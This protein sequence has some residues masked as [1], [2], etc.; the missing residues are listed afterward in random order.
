MNTSFENIP[1]L[2]QSK[3]KPKI[4]EI[5]LTIDGTRRKIFDGNCWQYLCIGD[6]N[7]RIQAKQTC[8]YH[9]ICRPIV[10]EV[11]SSEKKSSSITTGEIQMLPNGSRRIWRGARWHS[12]CRVDNCNIQAKDFCKNHQNQRMSLPNTSMK[13]FYENNREFVLS[14]LEISL[15]SQSKKRAR[16]LV[17]QSAKQSI[18]DLPSTDESHPVKEKIIQSPP[19]SPTQKRELHTRNGRLVRCN[20]LIWKH[21][22]AEKK[23]TILKRKYQ[24]RKAIS[25]QKPS[26]IIES[27]PAPSSDTPQSST[28]K[29]MTRT[30]HKRKITSDISNEEHIVPKRAKQRKAAL[31]KS[32]SL[33][34]EGTSSNTSVSYPSLP[35]DSMVIDLL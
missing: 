21:L 23:T 29:P 19:V 35:Y 1:R 7:C 15:Q 4:G 34:L 5:R 31:E 10:S 16:S 20:G 33:S 17:T 9:R 11:K 14:D 28:T 24:H 32:I 26:P 12:L 30:S 6:P 2:G 13:N 27:P 8:R 25:L 3:I 22:C 18:S